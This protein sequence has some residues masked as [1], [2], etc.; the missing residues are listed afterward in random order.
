[1]DFKSLDWPANQQTVSE[2]T[3]QLREYDTCILSF[4]I[5]LRYVYA[6]KDDYFFYIIL[7]IIW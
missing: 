2:S 5:A 6:F 7:P 4:L 1:M 3:V